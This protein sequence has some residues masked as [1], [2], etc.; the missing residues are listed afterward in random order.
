T[1]T[2][3][4]ASNVKAFVATDDTA[5]YA[6]ALAVIGAAGTMRGG[7]VVIPNKFMLVTNTLIDHGQ[8]IDFSCG[9]PGFSQTASGT[10]AG[11]GIIWAGPSGKPVVEFL[12]TFGA[13]FHDCAVIGNSNSANRPL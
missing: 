3:S 5:S 10:A 7:Q 4:T 1:Y 6:A 11:G 12:N 9:G 13:R 8:P 2:G